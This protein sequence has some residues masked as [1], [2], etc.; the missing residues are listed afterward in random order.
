MHDKEMQ[1]Y[2]LYSIMAIGFLTIPGI[3]LA[4]IKYRLPARQDQLTSFFKSDGILPAYLAIRGHRPSKQSGQSEEDYHQS[5]VDEFDKVFSLELAQEYGPTLYLVP[6]VAAS[7]TTVV[8]IIYLLNEATG[9]RLITFVPSSV[10]F[11]LLGAFAGSVYSVISRY[12]H[13]DLSPTSLWWI[14]FRYLI[15]PHMVC[16]RI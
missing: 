14:P 8:V 4:Y 12:S 13:A 2:F 6:I 3:C 15:A 16:S 1:A 11:G 7:L 9:Y 10:S 5:L